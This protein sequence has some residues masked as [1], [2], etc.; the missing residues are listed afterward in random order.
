M[1]TNSYRS[2]HTGSLVPSARFGAVAAIALAALGLGRGMAADPAIQPDHDAYHPG[3][4]I[5]VTFSGGPGGSKDWIGVYTPDAEPGPV[6]STVWRYV[7]DTQNGNQGLREGSVHF[8]GG[9]GLAGD[10]VVYFLLNDGYTKVAT[11]QFQV[12]DPS[13][14]LVRPSKR[15]FAPGEAI[16]ITFTNG[17]ANPKD[18]IGVYQVGQTPGGPQSTIWNYVDGTQNGNVAN[19]NGSVSFPSG[20]GVVGEYVAYLLLNDGYDILASERFRVAAPSADGARVLTLTPSDGTTDVPPT[21]SF[22][23]TLTN[24]VTQVAAGSVTLQLDGVAV[25]PQVTLDGGLT[26]VTYTSP[27]LPAALSAHTWVLTFRDTASPANTITTR[28]TVTVGNYTSVTLPSP[29][30]FENFDSVAEG[31]LPAGW[32]HKSYA[33]P[34]NEAEDLGDLGSATFARWTVV[35]ADRFQNPLVT[36][37]NPETTTEDY[38]RVLTPNPFNVVNGAAYTGPLAQGRFLFGNSGYANTAS[39]QVLFVES[40][41]FNLTGKTNIHVGFYSLWEQ[42]QDSIAAIE[43]S[44]N[45]GASWLPVAYF[46]D[47]NDLITVTNES[48]GEVT[49]DV[50]TTLTTEYGD[51]ARYTDDS[52]N[53]VGGTY[54]AFVSAP[55]DQ[56]LAPFIHGRANDNPAE[57]KRI[58]LLPLPQAANQG[59]VRVRFL[60]AGTDSWYFGIDNFGLYSVGA[61]STE[62]PSLAVSRD[63]STVVLSWPSTA[64]GFVLE[65][66]STAAGGGWQVVPGVTGNTHRVSTTVGTGAYY[67]L[68]Q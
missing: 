56:S 15:L 13:S 6:P 53:E 8:P 37:G 7:D 23:A 49:L 67:R 42:N 60:H 19:A 25:T 9:L 29:I 36:Y 45:Q 10:W 40:P 68:R 14:P 12:V 3:E 47:S 39:S 33:A 16:T 35:A 55:A 1:K 31:S 51:V 4:D 21:L 61:S 5:V 43:Y 2:V 41:D 32:T 48:T 63:G 18:W 57:S 38:R 44:I 54:G 20:L 66:S 27:A 46:L 59:S 52:G 28:S 34:A 26:T 22:R 50:A 24:G 58:E 30:V 11:N 65:T 17:P 64:A 62:R